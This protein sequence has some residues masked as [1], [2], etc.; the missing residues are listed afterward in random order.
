MDLDRRDLAGLGFPWGVSLIISRRGSTREAYAATK[1]AL[2]GNIAVAVGFILA[3]LLT[4][5]VADLSFGP[6]PGLILS[7]LIAE[8]LLLALIS[9]WSGV[10]QGNLRFGAIGSARIIEALGKLL[11]GV[12]L[13]IWGYGAVGAVGA[14]VCA[15]ALSLAYV[16]WTAR[17][18][19]FWRTRDWGDWQLFRGSMTIFVGLSALTMIINFDLIGI[20]L[21]IGGAKAVVL[22]GFYQAASMLPRMLVLLARTYASA[23]FPYIARADERQM[24]LYAGGAL[25]YIVLLVVAANLVMAA[26]PEAIITLI[27]PDSYIVAAPAMRYAALGSA[28]LSIA[29]VLTSIFQARNRQRPPAISLPLA[30][31]VELVAL[32]VLLPRYGI[33][34]AGLALLI[35]GVVACVMLLIWFVHA[36]GW[37]LRWSNLLRFVAAG[38]TLVAVLLLLPHDSDI[39]TFVTV[40]VALAAYAVALA[41]VRLLRPS[42]LR[43]LS[44]GLPVER[45]G[46]AG[47]VFTMCLQTVERLNSV[48][49]GSK[50]S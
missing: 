18:F 1:S 3:L 23:L 48:V 49:P 34:G 25:K 21:F 22:A 13:V 27:F 26:I 35:A 14:T 29:T 39:W 43:V 24:P 50:I 5:V 46:R 36:F 17:S 16:V 15:T 45:L 20:D 19:T 4:V 40:C 9:V 32:A 12:A 28:L 47:V 7:L 37:Q 8:T 2:A 44:G 31:A 11:G 10:L 42:D 6:K 38:A 41:L 30:A 33:V